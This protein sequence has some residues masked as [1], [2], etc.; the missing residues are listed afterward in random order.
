V[1]IGR[2][3]VDHVILRLLPVPPT[4]KDDKKNG[5]TLAWG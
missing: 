4:V 5:R 1:P 2:G 3:G